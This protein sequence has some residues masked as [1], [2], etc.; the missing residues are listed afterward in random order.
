MRPRVRWPILPFLALATL[1]FCG[2]IGCGQSSM[3]LQGQVQKMQQQ[4]L[5]L[6]RQNEQLQNR[7]NSLDRDNQELDTLLAQS[8]Q[9]TKILEDETSAIRQQ[10]SDA[11]TQ[12]AKSRE[13]RSTT[14]K[15]VKTMT[16]SL[17]R[18]GRVSISPNSSV[19]GN[20]PNIDLP[21]IE[22]RRDGE[23]IRVVLPADRLFNPGTAQLSAQ[24]TTLLSQVAA[25]VQRIY[26]DQMIGVEGHT[27]SHPASMAG[28]RNCHELSVAW[29]VAV[30]NHLTSQTRL[31]PGQLLVTGHGA[32][33]PVYSN[34]SPGGT[35]RNR[36]VELV[37]YPE[38]AGQ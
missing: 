30:H 28:Y 29:A 37:I 15:Q 25:E 34:A 36:R 5:A 26:P 13:E 1:A 2:L 31:Q 24:A 22:V 16:A 10:L 33:D 23:V 38:R 20:L 7:A 32:N 27:D 3:V 6:T 18:Q 9:T 12:L 4:Q 11:T 21:G 17:E 35:E 8:R 19:R 14:E